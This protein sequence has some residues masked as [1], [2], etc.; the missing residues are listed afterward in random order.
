[1][2]DEKGVT[3]IDALSKA[4]A[5]RQPERLAYFAFDLLHLDGHDLR[6]CPIE[7]RKVLLRD[8]IAVA[9]R[10]RLVTLDHIVG[11]GAALFEAVRHHDGEGIVSKRSGSPYRG[12]PSRDWLKIK[13]SETGVFVITGFSERGPGR[14]EARAV[15]ELRDSVLVPAGRVKFGLAGKRL[16]QRLDPLH[17]G[18]S[19]RSGIVPVRPELVET[20]PPARCEPYRAS[21]AAARARWGNR[22]IMK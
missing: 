21:H 18:P 3:H 2:P 20:G 4:L 11:N 9:A 16:W 22:L 17:D 10:P 1:V 15:A 5:K 12:G 14:L 7:D 19:N 8:V 6:D 13:V